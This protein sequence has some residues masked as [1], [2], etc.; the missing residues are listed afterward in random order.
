MDPKKVILKILKQHIP[1]DAE[2]IEIPPGDELGDYAY[3]CFHL[4]KEMKKAPAKIAE[5]VAKHAQPQKPFKKI[6]ATGPYINFFLESSDIAK[7]VLPRI[8]KQQDE[9]GKPDQIDKKTILIEYPSPNTNKPLHLGHIRNMVLGSSMSYIFEFLGNKVIQANLNND[10]GVHICKSMLAYQ[11]WGDN[12][13]PDIKTDH[14]V[15]KFYVEFSKRLKENPG[16][17][18]EAQE[19]LVKWEN[20]DEKVRELWKLMS[21]WA[22]GGFEETYER[23]GVNFDKYY[24]ESD[25]YTKGKEIVLDGLKKGIFKKDDDGAV[26]ADLEEDKLGKKVLLRPDGTCI[27]ITQDL[28]L[29]IQK[30]KDYQLDTSIYIVAHEQ[31]YHFKVLF[32]LLDML[33]H[34]W[35]DSCHHL[36][37]G[38]VNLPEGRMKSREGTVVDADDLMANMKDLAA[39]EIR[40]RHN[41]L[42][43]EVVEERAWQ[44]GLGALKFF[45][46]KID[47]VKDILF[48]PKESIS[49]EGETGPYVQYA[50]ARICAVFR[51]F[52]E[53]HGPELDEVRKKHI[54]ED[55]QAPDTSELLKDYFANS[56]IDYNQLTHGS[57]ARLIKLLYNFPSIIAEAGKKYKPNLV[58]NN[59]I[60]IAQAFN[61]FYHNC[62]ILIEDVKQRNARLLLAD[63][64]RHVLEIGL[65]L[66]G[67][68]APKE[69]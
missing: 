4:A 53:Q 22:Y 10:R 46:V 12:K 44:I 21:S 9:Y 45:I 25:F 14:F 6:K 57:E 20:G 34:S 11:K 42:A 65:G 69:M 27:Y 2:Q 52:M 15:G 58:A 60:D 5:E 23:F 36:S 3:P 51:K 29:A 50:H 40:K 26:Y 24:Y 47:P 18:A 68:E 54:A 28:Y 1:V 48:N 63:C 43:E 7:F 33:G 32:K 16:L 38:L 66:L 41:D 35:A 13:L 31:N 37:Y 56:K 59:L 19:M 49:F 61:D 39:V 8:Q 64:T 17:E 30:T 67:I 62:P 55:K